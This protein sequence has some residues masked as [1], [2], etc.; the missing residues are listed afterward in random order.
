MSTTNNAPS[1]LLSAL[2]TGQAICK[3]PRLVTTTLHLHRV[4]KPSRSEKTRT[5]QAAA[6]GHI[7]CIWRNLTL[8][9]KTR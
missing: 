9:S 8:T 1:W 3:T 4:G 5:P 6:T 7:K 2:R